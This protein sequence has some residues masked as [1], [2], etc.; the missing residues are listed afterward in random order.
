M[1]VMV[2]G[3]GVDAV[4]LAL[5][6]PILIQTFL[7]GE[8]IGRVCVHDCGAILK[9]N[10]HWGSASAAGDVICAPPHT[11]FLTM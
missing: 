7:N 9:S 11:H 3:G 1:S 8:R 6:L 2:T 10:A 5:F 4:S